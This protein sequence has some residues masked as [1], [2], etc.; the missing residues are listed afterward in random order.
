MR[1]LLVL[2]V[3]ASCALDAP[4]AFEEFDSLSKIEGV[5]FTFEI[6]GMTVSFQPIVTDPA[7]FKWKW[8]FGDGNKSIEYAPVHTYATPGTYAVTF[9]VGDGGDKGQAI[10]YV[11]VGDPAPPPDPGTDYPAYPVPMDNPDVL[12]DTPPISL[13]PANDIV[14]VGISMS[15]GMREFAYWS[16]TRFPHSDDLHF[17]NCALGGVALD[18]WATTNTPWT[19]CLESVAVAGWS[20]SDVRVVIHK[21]ALQFEL[22]DSADNMYDLL[23]TFTTKIDKYFPQ[24]EV[25]YNMTR[26]L[27]D[28]ALKDGRDEPLAHDHS[29][30]LDTWLRAN[31]TVSGRQYVWGPYIWAPDCGLGLVNGSGVCYVREDYATDGVHPVAGALEKI[32][33]MMDTFF[34]TQAW[35]N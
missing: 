24:A 29:R 4:V 33:A 31:P 3:V 14:V 8:N 10:K 12:L 20:V 23:T 7:V 21:S 17:V 18:K 1:Q 5:D 35:Y 15:N 9:V 32:A 11:T 16:D 19:R 13:G 26:S 22:G 25:V 6:D 30:V 2:L 34:Q 27:G 28:Y